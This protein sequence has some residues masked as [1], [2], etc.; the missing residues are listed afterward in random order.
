MAKQAKRALKSK[1]EVVP[2]HPTGWQEGE[3]YLQAAKVLAPFETDGWVGFREDLLTQQ[4]RVPH[5]SGHAYRV[6]FVRY[7]RRA[8]RARL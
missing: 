5:P 3:A 1:V 6:R 8:R 2:F 7:G 4:N